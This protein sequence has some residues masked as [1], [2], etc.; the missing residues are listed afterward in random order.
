MVRERVRKESCAGLNIAG[1]AL[2]F[3]NDLLPC[4]NR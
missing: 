4:D 3:V 1:D 2:S